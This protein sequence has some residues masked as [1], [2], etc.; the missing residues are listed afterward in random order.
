M[1]A[2]FTALG[3]VFDYP[4]KRKQPVDDVLASFRRS[5]VW[6]LPN[7]PQ[8][9]TTRQLAAGSWQLAA[10]SWQTSSTDWPASHAAAFGRSAR[11]WSGSRR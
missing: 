7:D 4:D 11:R 3:S 6:H 2:G 5:Q 10:G 9:R 1:T 8:T